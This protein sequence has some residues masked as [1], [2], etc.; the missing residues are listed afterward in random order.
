M[1]VQFVSCQLMYSLNNAIRAGTHGFYS[2]YK[3]LVGGMCGLLNGSFCSFQ[4]RQASKALLRGVICTNITSFH[5]DP[6]LPAY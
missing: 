2:L 6:N 3:P 4:T 1:S 5:I